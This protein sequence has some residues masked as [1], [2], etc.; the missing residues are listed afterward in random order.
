[1]K[2]KP[3]LIIKRPFSSSHSEL[4]LKN[5]TK[6]I[7]KN[8]S[9]KNL[10]ILSACLSAN[11]MIPNNIN[12]R[13]KSPKY[14]YNYTTNFSSSKFKSK[15][16][17]RPQTTNFSSNLFS[18]SD[19]E[20][21]D[22]LNLIINSNPNQ[23]NR[24]MI[25]KKMEQINPMYIIGTDKNMK[26]PKLSYKTEEVFYNYNLLYGNKT[27]N[28]IRTY[29]PKM[30]PSSSSVKV[31][32]KKFNHTLKEDFPI[33][34]EEEIL[35]F[36]NSKCK[37]IGISFRENIFYKFKDFCNNRCK[38]RI[39]DLSDSFLGINSVKFLIGILYNTEKISRLNL[40]KN[41]IGDVGTELLVNSLKDSKSLLS[42]DISSNSISYKGGMILFTKFINQQSI[43]NLDIS[44]H[45]GINRNRL[46]SKGITNIVQ[47]LE[48]NL[49]LE[50]LNISSN[51]LKNEGFELICKGLNNNIN[52][53]ELNIGNND[54]NEEGLEQYLKYID[55]TKII[56]L[57][58]S[59]NKIK[60][61]GLII[62]ANNLRHFPELKILNISNCGIKFK[63]F[64]ELLK[65]LQ[66]VR[67]IE[68]LDASNNNI[69]SENFEELK[70]FFCAFGLRYLNL[71]KCHLEDETSY[72]LG[73]CLSLNETI[74]KLV[75]S[76]NKISDTGFSSFVQL[77]SN[78]S[79]LEHIDLSC[80]FI[81]EK[82]AIKFISNAENNMTL[83]YINFY[84][85]HIRNDIGKHVLRILDTNKTLVKINL[86]FNR[87]QLKTI[88]EINEKLKINSIKKRN[89]L[90][91]DIQRSIRDLE[92]D[93]KL[94]RILIRQ[95]KNKNEQQKSIR[96]KIKQENK[97]YA[98]LINKEHKLVQNKKDE[99][100]EVEKKLNNIDKKISN[101]SAN[102]ELLEQNLN[103]NENEIKKQIKIENRAK[104]E[105]EVVNMQAKAEYELTKKEME[106][107]INKTR[108][109][110]GQSQDK[111]I[112]AQKALNN[113]N[114]TLKKLNKLYEN[115]MN[116]KK[117]SPIKK[118]SRNN[119]RRKSQ[120]L[121]K[122]GE[123]NTNEINTNINNKEHQSKIRNSVITISTSSTLNDIIKKET[124]IKNKK[125]I[126]KTT[127]K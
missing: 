12:F 71:S 51:S 67:R 44:S 70:M 94:F 35:L 18:R 32:L 48:K 89:K 119:T 64:R 111:I 20:D 6:S 114:I 82:T 62:F 40:S 116:P 22:Y 93:P 75:L 57:N 50:K 74:K 110:Y 1:M 78:N 54:I 92:F 10:R 27:Q 72:I 14:K 52:L 101:I 7:K 11:D 16:Q 91:P 21:L 15:N 8:T 63:G 100:K 24:E 23:F 113:L 86:L 34:N 56:S 104:G 45:E 47:F 26:R 107:I 127:N 123:L 112:D 33:F 43:I 28:L 118:E 98:L 37:D 25:Q 122:L 109:K 42:L 84:D 36:C 85:N 117:L 9:K 79:T 99:L 120:F 58:I 39:A 95:I 68:S 29:S 124:N 80:N 5:K 17:T 66:S 59:G 115:L 69:A 125:H 73:E 102:M 77:L 90:I 103:I 83:K 61:E 19:N 4:T 81:S 49:F 30:H 88:E 108:V 65:I 41:N 105:I 97:N 121:K 3:S 38:N 96:K 46:T 126:L 53:R 60:D 55:T 87:V 2:T 31:F 76:K 13:I 106:D